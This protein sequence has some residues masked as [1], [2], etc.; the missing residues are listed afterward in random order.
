VAPTVCKRTVSGTISLPCSGCFSPFPHGT[1]SLSV[2]QKYLA[3]P[4]GPGS[5]RQD[6]SCPVLL[7][8]LLTLYINTCTGLSPLSCVFP[9][10]F[11]FV[12]I[13]YIVVLQPRNS[14]NYHGLGSSPFDR[15]YSGNHFCFLFLQVLRCFSSLG[16]LP[17]YSGYQAFNLVGCPIRKSWDRRLFAPPPSLSQLVTS[18]FA[19]ESQ[20]IHRTPLFTFFFL[21]CH[22]ITLPFYPICQRTFLILKL[23]YE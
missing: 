14:L 10:S 9:D 3:L 12:Y 8:I 15:H 16:S 13:T 6:S 17:D 18:F 19:S 20:G 5:F 2:S 11:H 22:L 7:R 1:C 21:S 23:F 4:D